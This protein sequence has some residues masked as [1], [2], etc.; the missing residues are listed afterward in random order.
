MDW[1]GLLSQAVEITSTFNVKLALILYFLCAVGEVGVA[2][3]Y[4]LETVWLLAGYQLA[5]KQITIQEV[6]YLWLIAQAGRQTGSVTLYYSG[7]LGMMPLKKLYHK[8][9]KPHLP[10]RQFISP[11]IMKYITNPSPFS[12]AIARLL[13]LR[14]P[15]ALTTSLKRRLSHLVLGVIISSVIWDGIYLI[16]GCTVGAAMVPKPLNMLVYS[17]AGL[18]GLYLVTLG[19]RQLFRLRSTKKKAEQQQP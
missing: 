9:I 5:Q 13:G 14:I 15:M 7:I 12:I 11:G 18:T 1:Q 8:Y 17:L 6:I 3:P 2:L 4:I 10:K 16:I 19:I